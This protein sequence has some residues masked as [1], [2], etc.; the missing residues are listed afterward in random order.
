M[1]VRDSVAAAINSAGRAVTAINDSPGFVAQ[2]MTAM[3]ANLGCYMAEVSLATPDDIDLAMKLGLNYP[4]GPLEFAAD[5]GAAMP[6]DT[7]TTPCHHRRRSVP[8][9]DVAE[10]A[11]GTR[12]AG[13]HTTLTRGHRNGHTLEKSGRTARTGVISAKT[14]SA[15][16]S[17]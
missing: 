6:T 4:L 13:S 2:R 11:R 5:L 1:A 12:S 10:A 3:I 8:A 16:G 15:G 7:R 9:D 17:T 14:I